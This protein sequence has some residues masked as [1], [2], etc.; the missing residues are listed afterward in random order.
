M[1]QRIALA[2]A[3]SSAGKDSYAAGLIDGMSLAPMFDAKATGRLDKIAQC[4]TGMS[5]TQVAAILTAHLRSKP[6]SWHFGANHAMYQ[7]LVERCPK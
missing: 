5:D 4:L 1:H 6:E 7:A 2:L 3:L